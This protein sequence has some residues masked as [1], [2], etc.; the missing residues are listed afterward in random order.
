MIYAP[1][2]GC[3]CMYVYVDEFVFMPVWGEWR[4]CVTEKWNS[5]LLYKHYKIL[6]LNFRNLGIIRFFCTKA[7]RVLIAKS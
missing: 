1:R 3:V 5:A 6:L 4:Q 7:A 2:R